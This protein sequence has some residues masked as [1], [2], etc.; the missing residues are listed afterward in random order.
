MWL[1]F[2]PFRRVPVTRARVKNIRH[3]VTL[4]VSAN[5]KWQFSCVRRALKAREDFPTKSMGQPT[6]GVATEPPAAAAAR[7]KEYVAAL[8]PT[9]APLARPRGYQHNRSALLQ[10]CSS[11]EE[12]SSL[13]KSLEEAAGPALQTLCCA[14][15]LRICIISFFPHAGYEH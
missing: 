14:V 12:A 15:L 8:F 11:E 2:G 9:V 6:V 13:Q 3:S 10:A 1:T 5:L 4:S 7:M